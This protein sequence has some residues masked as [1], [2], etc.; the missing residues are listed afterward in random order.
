MHKN[1]GQCLLDYGNYKTT[2]WL[3]LMAGKILD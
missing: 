2:R 3:H 1:A